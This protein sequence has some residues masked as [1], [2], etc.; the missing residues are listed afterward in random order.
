MDKIIY[1]GKHPLTTSVTRH[2]HTNWELIFCTSG[3]GQLVFDDVTLTYA[4]N[5]VAII[6]PFLPHSNLSTEGFTNVHIH[7]SDTLFSNT[8]PLLVHAD[9][10]GFLLDAF[11]AAFYYFSGT[12]SDRSS[13]LPIYGHLISTFLRTR[14]PTDLRSEVVHDIETNILQNFSDPNYDL[15][16]YLHS[17]PFSSEYLKKLFKQETG[18]TPQQYLRDRRLEN[19]AGILITYFGKGNISEA[20]HLS[21]FNDPLYFS[22]LFKKR[23]GVAPRNYKPDSAAPEDGASAKPTP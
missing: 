16:A 23:Y 9:P 2:S 22:R 10:N 12:S 20:A 3:S 15:T 19:A 6:P 13:L 18:I 11:N 17:L 8:E 5:D 14:Q 4:E 1:A 7:L 21:G